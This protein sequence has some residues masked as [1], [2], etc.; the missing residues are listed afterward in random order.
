M[1]IYYKMDF[2]SGFPEEDRVLGH[3]NG[4]LVPNGRLYFDRMGQGEIIHD[5]PVF[6]YFHLQSFGPKEEWEWRLQDVHGFIGEYPT[7]GGWYISD[8]FK[9]LLDKFSIAS[10]HYYATKLLYKGEKLDYWIFRYSVEPSKNVDFAK[11]IFY[12]KETTE[13]VEGIPS[14]D[15]F[16]LIRRRYRKELSKTLVLKKGVYHAYFDFAYNIIEGD[17]L[18]SEKL[19]TAIQEAGLVGLEFKELDYEVEFSNPV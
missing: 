19:K 1:D 12:V 10:H 17:L 2:K 16:L 5:A 8:R 4:G 7:G 11:S 3:A 14:W 13:L 9:N 6:D 18:V 15:E